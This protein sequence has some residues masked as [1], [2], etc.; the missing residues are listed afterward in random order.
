MSP[1]KV[2]LIGEV[3]KPLQPMDSNSSET[4]A[5]ISLGGVALA[6][7]NIASKGASPGKTTSLAKLTPLGGSADNSEVSARHM[8]G[9]ESLSRCHTLS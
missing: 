3:F 4:V 2:R 6:D 1:R 8:P 7:G 5:V 9:L